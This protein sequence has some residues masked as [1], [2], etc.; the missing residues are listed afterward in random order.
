MS[1][2]PSWF[3]SNP[4]LF[5]V[6]H[7]PDDGRARGGVLLAPSLFAEEVSAHAALRLLAEQLAAAGLA[8][9]RLDYPGTGDS[10]DPE[11][12]TVDA[13]RTGLA[14]GLAELRRLTPQWLAA[15]GL[16]FGAT[17]LTGCSDAKALD[18]LV[19]WDPVA[20]NRMLREQ[21]SLYRLTA[22]AAGAEVNAADVD[23]LH[24]Q[25]PGRL[26]EQI[27]GTRPQPMADFPGACLLLERTCG[28]AQIGGPATTRL[29]VDGQAEMLEVDVDMRR[30]PTATLDL[31]AGWLEPLAP[32]ERRPTGF[33]PTHRA[34]VPAPDAPVTETIES[35]G[36]GRLFAIRTTP[37]SEQRGEL[38]TVAFLNTAT[39]HHIGPGR[40]WVELARKLAADGF[41]SVRLDLPGLGETDPV[42]GRITGESYDP[43]FID[44][45]AAA[46]SDVADGRP[47]VNVG[48]CSGAY[49][50]MEWSLRSPAAGVVAV[51]PV[52]SFVPWEAANGPL[53]ARRRIV[54]VPNTA[55]RRLGGSSRLAAVKQHLPP[56]V[57]RLLAAA[58]VHPAPTAGL[59]LV[60]DS[61]SHLVLALSGSDAAPY[62]N[63]GNAELNRLLTSGRLDVATFPE[64]D[65]GLFQ[66]ASRRQVAEIVL[67]HVRRMAGVGA[68]RVD[69]TAGG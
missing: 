33:R 23:T 19:F 61:G 69:A 4:P 13:W 68:D 66:A 24:F 36:P 26:A 12:V 9:L 21:T 53:D 60:V 54:H 50:A 30:M 25:V 58:K 62:L 47:V 31:I 57:W 27:R 28:Q 34:T 7:L 51:N 41:I 63:R 17:L 22:G 10:G 16:R 38:P 55:A 15:V 29:T 42:A 6:L 40:L 1:A 45:L 52:L 11:L 64:A 44:D 8:V 3:G 49:H 67:G 59:R 65:H 18:A 37:T 43:A 39:D 32:T 35:L 2:T 56:V 20:G 46:A 5:G 48:L 14:A